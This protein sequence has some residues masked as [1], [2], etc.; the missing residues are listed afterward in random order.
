MALLL[1]SSIRVK[2]TVSVFG[3]IM[4]TVTNCGCCLGT[5]LE[6]FLTQTYLGFWSASFY[7][8]APAITSAVVSVC[9]YVRDGHP[10]LLESRQ[11]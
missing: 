3:N 6:A 7:R 9:I 10:G 1:Y 11:Y 2:Y 8:G 5:Q 4:F